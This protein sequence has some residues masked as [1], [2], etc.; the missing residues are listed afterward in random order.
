MNEH[1]GEA[2][3]G[4][5]KEPPGP[6]VVNIIRVKPDEQFTVRSDSG[7]QIKIVIEKMP[8]G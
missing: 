3:E 8:Q 6:K 5:N 2:G 4:R 7:G 1:R